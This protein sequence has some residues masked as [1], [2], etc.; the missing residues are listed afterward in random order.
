[1]VNLTEMD[2][3]IL[4]AVRKNK[5][6]SIPDLKRLLP[7]V[8]S[9]E[10][11]VK[12]LSTPEYRQLPHAS[13]K[14]GNSSYLT[15]IHK[16]ENNLIMPTGLY[17]LTDLGKKELQDHVQFHRSQTKEFWFKSIWTPILVTLATNLLISG[18]KWLSPLIL[19]L[20]T[21]TP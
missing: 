21:N 12:Q 7:E 11:R 3:K 2:I 15:E 4:K 18:L 13:I 17:R 20:L 8:E 6:I 1:M 19:K 10:Y 5:S 14:I 9:L 16:E